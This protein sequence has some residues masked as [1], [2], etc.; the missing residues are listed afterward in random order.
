MAFVKGKTK[1]PNDNV[2]TPVEIAKAI[3]DKMPL[4]DGDIVLDASAGKNVFYDNYPDYVV[5]DRCEIDDNIDF[6]AYNKKVDWIITNPPYSKYK[7]WMKHSYEIA[8]NIVYLIPMSKLV[9]SWG[10]IK[11]IASYG[12]V[13]YIYILP[14]GKCGFPFGFPACAVWIQRDYKGLIQVELYD[15]TE[16]EE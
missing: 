15:T 9:S 11:D 4:K 3:I 8:D 10:R 7:E 6:F 16:S 14:A 12:G 13:K 5:K 2:Y 1:S